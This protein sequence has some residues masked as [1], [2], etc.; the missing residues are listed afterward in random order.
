MR[1]NFAE[2][3]IGAVP[4]ECVL[5][6]MLD[7]EDYEQAAALG[8]ECL[9]RGRDTP[10]LHEYLASAYTHLGETESCIRSLRSVIEKCP[11]DASAYRK[12]GQAFLRCQAFEV[13][14]D[15]FLCSIRLNPRDLE[16][17]LG[18]SSCV[19]RNRP[20][21]EALPL[22]ESAIRDIGSVAQ[23]LEALGIQLIDLGRYGEAR[24]CA[25]ELLRRN[26]ASPAAFVILSKVAEEYEHDYNGA[27]QLL[28]QA[29]RS[30]PASYFPYAAYLQLLS[31]VS[32]WDEAHEIFAQMYARLGFRY[33]PISPTT[34]NWDGSCPAGKTILLDSRLGTGYGDALHFSRFAAQLAD[35]GAQIGIVARRGSELLLSRVP[36]S[37]FVIRPGD[38]VPC[39]YVCE[40]MFLWLLLRINQSDACGSVPYLCSHREVPPHLINREINRIRV[41]V[42]WESAERRR[43]NPY[44]ARH[45]PPEHLAC[46]LELPNVQVFSLQKTGVPDALRRIAGDKLIDLSAY[47]VD[48]DASASIVSG[49]DVIVTV[50]TA[51]AHLA[52]ALGKPVFIVLSYSSEWRWLVDRPDTP[53]YPTARLFRQT[54]PGDWTTVLKNVSDELAKRAAPPTDE[55]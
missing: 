53:W 35:R 7:R 37:S 44:I 30:N 47:L 41:G 1:D 4:L 9:R 24:Q 42:V 32:R 11:G 23:V 39:D 34:P 25:H 12:L 36:G 54:R 19:T 38:S 2:M 8:R 51:M 33:P 15:S 50:D 48:F 28:I 3:E 6:R 21:G 31:K 29:F 22:A 17:Y 13:A 43:D 46:L 27:E 5:Q 26:Q 20:F 14:E 18:F 52:G 45:L 10:E 49:L 55:R 40:L 16:A